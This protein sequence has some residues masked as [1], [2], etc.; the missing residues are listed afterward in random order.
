MDTLT[1]PLDDD[2]KMEIETLRE[3]VRRLALNGQGSDL[4]RPLTL[5]AQGDRI[6]ERLAHWLLD[7]EQK[8]VL[9]DHPWHAF[10]LHAVA[11]LC[12]IGLMDGSG[13]AGGTSIARCSHDWI[14]QHWQVLGDPECA[15]RRDHGP[16]LPADGRFIRPR[17]TP[18]RFRT[19]PLCRHHDQH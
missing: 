5:V 4:S 8:Q 9:D 16:D 18:R 17:L 19:I 7:D 13:R 11:Y 15:L 10:F 14:Q 6:V 2:M 1:Q 12:D 3:S